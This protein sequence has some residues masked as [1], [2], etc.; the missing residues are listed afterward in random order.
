MSA[1]GLTR[2]IAFR[3]LAMVGILVVLVAVIF[4]LE[5]F[6]P[7]DPVH[8]MVGANASP[9]TIAAARHQ[10]GYDKPLPQ[11][12]VTY[13][14]DVARGNLQMSLRTRRPV[15]TDL[16]DYLPA[17]IE[18][19]MYGL[20]L[21]VILGGALGLATALRVRGSGVVRFVLLAFASAPPFLLAIFCILL[22]YRR[23]GWLPATGRSSID[24]APTGPTKLLTID[25]MLH[26]RWD[27]VWDGYRHLVLP[28]FCVAI[29]PAVAIGRVL[30][31]SLVGTLHSDHV[32]T[33]R[34][35]G[36][37]ESTVVGKHAVRNSIGPALSM[38]GLQVG[39]MF[40]GVIVVE[41]V[42]AWPGIGL[43]T[44]QSIPRTD[45]PAIAGVTLVLGAVYVLVNALVDIGQA[46]ADPRIAI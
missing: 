13:L 18:L 22:F 36:L 16:A 40:A 34:S 28:A 25:G 43:Y 21:A 27:V 9:A 38:T 37:R 3:L 42:F 2:F 5:R 15:T 20:L 39:L 33:A 45:F 23:L 44:A 30:R 11:Q 12:F 32:R 14:G 17:T 24:N 41:E 19:A 4:A 6:T 46:I 35:K 8:V 31:S 29:V 10:L 1:G 7:A 26:G